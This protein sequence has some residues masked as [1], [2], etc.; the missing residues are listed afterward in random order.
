MINVPEL[1]TE[2]TDRNMTMRYPLI[3]TATAVSDEGV[4][5]PD[6]FLA[7]LRLSLGAMDRAG[8]ASYRFSLFISSVSVYADYAYVVISDTVTG[9]TIA[10][11]DPISLL[12][13]TGDSIASRTVYIR[14]SGDVPVNGTIIIGTCE[15]IKNLQGV[16]EFGFSAGQ[17]FPSNILPAESVLSGFYIGGTYVTGDVTIQEGDGVT[18]SYNAGTNT[19]TINAATTEESSPIT[20][21]SGLLDAVTER[22]GE[23][24]TS[25][26][27]VTPDNTG[28]VEIAAVDC[29]EVTTDMAGH[30]V[31]FSNPCGSACASDEFLAETY[32]RIAEINKNYATLVNLYQSVSGALSQMSSRVAAVFQTE[33][34]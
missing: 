30:S 14:P 12:L 32:R 8:D 28:N 26:N 1:Y 17:L 21:N 19:I 22:F 24:V 25:I 3:D 27:G 2:F 4:A 15:D 10:K 7:D 33:T 9:E 29:L 23:P 6:S 5:L 34:N 13:N 11:S 20:S 18:L 16:H 31:T